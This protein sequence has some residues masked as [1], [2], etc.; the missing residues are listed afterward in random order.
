M[1]DYPRQAHDDQ[2]TMANKCHWD[3]LAALHSGIAGYGSD[4]LIAGGT[5]L[6][7]IEKQRLGD[8]SGK[9]VLHL[10]CH[11]GLDTLSLARLGAEVTGVDFSPKAIEAAANLSARTGLQARF[12]CSDIYELDNNPLGAFDIIYTSY[13]IV[14]W[15]C[16]LQ[17]WARILER[18]LVSGGCL[19]LF[20]THP[21]VHMLQAQPH[22]KNPVLY[23]EGRYFSTGEAHQYVAQGSYADRTASLKEPVNFKWLH[24]LSELIM[25]LIGADL[26]ITAFDEFPFLCYQ[27]FDFMEPSEG[28][29]WVLPAGLSLPLTVYLGASRK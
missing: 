8:V 7:E 11:I 16:D 4:R 21:L 24:T 3:E 22:S 12:V 2:F 25:A 20:E 27:K 23:Y 15:L 13:G 26:T 9:R 28:G 5:T 6:N 1:T 19:H 29:V 18:H 10:Q 17:R 14:E